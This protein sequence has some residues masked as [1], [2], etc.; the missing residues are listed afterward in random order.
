M[1]RLA[2]GGE[3]QSPSAT[4]TACITFSASPEIFNSASRFTTLTS[5]S[6]SRMR[7]FSSKE[8][9]ISMAYSIRSKLMVCS[10]IHVPRRPRFPFYINLFLCVYPRQRTEP[11]CQKQ[12]LRCFFGGIFY[13]Q[14]DDFPDLLFTFA[15]QCDGEHTVFCFRFEAMA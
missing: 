5:K 9:K 4:L 6:C 15:E 11:R 13:R 8:P 7:I 2:A 10:V 3:G 14:L 12:V 1:D